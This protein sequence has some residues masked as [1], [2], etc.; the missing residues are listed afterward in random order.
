MCMELSAQQL[1]TL[2]LVSTAFSPLKMHHSVW[3]RFTHKSAHTRG[4]P[5]FADGTIN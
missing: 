1:L 5:A 2:T 3:D 4:K